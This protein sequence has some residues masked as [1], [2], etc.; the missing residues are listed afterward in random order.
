MNKVVGL[1]AQ[2]NQ[3]SIGE[4][5]AQKQGSLCCETLAYK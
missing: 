3:L 2:D 4:E 1:W 5:A